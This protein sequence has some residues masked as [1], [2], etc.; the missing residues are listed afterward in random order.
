[1]DHFGEWLVVSALQQLLLASGGDP[2][3][4]SVA[5]LLHGDGANGST[6]IKDSSKSNKTASI[7]GLV[8]ISTAQSKFG[9]SSIRFNG[10][11]DV[12]FFADA[13][14]LAPSGDFT[15]EFFVY[16]IT[17]APDSYMFNKG[18]GVSISNASYG[19]T[20]L[21]GVLYWYASST[22]ASYDVGGEGTAA[23]LIGTP[24]VGAWTHIAITRAGNVYRGFMNGTQV[25]T[26]T[27]ALTPYSTSPRGLSI[28]GGFKNTWGSTS[29]G[30]LN[31][32]TN[33]YIDEFRLTTGVAR[34][35]ANFTP[36]TAPFP[37]A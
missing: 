30:N 8:A 36:P 27:L 21:S 29:S 15:I 19:M 7:G 18:G 3:F 32:G 24:T 17:S 20:M 26:Q 37:N 9:G 1:M 2:F 16:V 23:G 5:L 35:T 25:Y 6:T 13:A 28:G 10:A 22:G 14:N 34:Y 33:S 31:G 11:G 4:S 12:L